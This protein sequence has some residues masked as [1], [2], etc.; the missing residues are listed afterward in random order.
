L[1]ELDSQILSLQ[2]GPVRQTGLILLSLRAAV[3]IQ[4]EGAKKRG[5]S[6]SGKGVGSAPLLPG[7]RGDGDAK[8]EPALYPKNGS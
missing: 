5:R 2:I 7:P 3:R 4:R 1:S 6:Q 8:P